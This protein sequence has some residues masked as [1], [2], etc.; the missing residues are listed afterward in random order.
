MA[1]SEDVETTTAP[2]ITVDLVDPRDEQAFSRWF[3]VL[4][5][6]EEHDRPGEPGELRHEQRQ[7]ALD[8]SGPDADTAV[9]LLRASVDGAAV[10]ASRLEL[11]A[12]DNLHLCELV[13]SVQPDARRRGVARALQ[14]QVERCARE[15]GRTTLL[16]FVDEPPGQE[17]RSGNRAAALALGYTVAQQEV[18]RDIDLPLPAARVEQL[19]RACRPYA[20]HYVL[21]VWQDACPDDLVDDLAE[22]HRQMSTDVPKDETDW[23]E[24]VWDAA[25]LRRSEQ[26]SVTMGRTFVGVGAVHAPTGRMV[27][28]TCLGVPRVRP[29]RAYQWETLVSAPHRGHR[30]GMLVKLAGLQELAARSPQTRVISTWNA[31]ENVPMIA[32]NDA[33]GARTNGV[34]AVLQ[35]V[36]S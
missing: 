28:F 36:L 8:G 7:L 24:E 32:V 5:A 20:A 18:R 12:R 15:R 14:A 9:L 19:E 3:E 33:L 16:G 30:L 13:L 34:L 29:E 1:P 11:P 23:R 10:G 35:K 26:L 31:R 21:R 2:G 6:A 25:R 27:A 4:R 17:G 22:L